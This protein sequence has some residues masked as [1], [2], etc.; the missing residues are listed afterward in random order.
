MSEPSPLDALLMYLRRRFAEVPTA[1][2]WDGYDFVHS[3]GN[4][5]TALLYAHLFM[6]EFVEV[7]GQ[8]FLRDRLDPSRIP[9]L[10][11]SMAEAAA[12]SPTDLKR[13]AG[14]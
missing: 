4:V 12:K 8:V 13:L 3:C 9:D 14:S 7:E 1:E 11:S 5:P 6:P 2:M 10:K